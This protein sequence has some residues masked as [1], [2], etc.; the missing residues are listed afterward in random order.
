MAGCNLGCT[1][2]DTK[3]EETQRLTQKQLADM[4]KLHLVVITGGEPLLQDLEPLITELHMQKHRIQIETNGT[5]PPKFTQYN[6][7][8]NV[9]F[10][11]SP[12]AE[13]CNEISDLCPFFKVLVEESTTEDKIKQYPLHYT[14]LQPLSNKP[15]NIARAVELCKSLD[16]SMSLQW[17]K[18]INIP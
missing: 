8:D 6:W 9:T 4:C 1:F 12:K 2:C 10:V 16:V 15:E 18:L 3:H 11:V 14:F 5:V 7:A 13:V 17:H